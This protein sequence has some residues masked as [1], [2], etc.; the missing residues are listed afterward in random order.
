MVSLYKGV[1]RF[2]P[3]PDCKTLTFFKSILRLIKFFKFGTQSYKS[4]RNWFMSNL[5]D[6]EL[7]LFL[8]AFTNLRY[9]YK[10]CLNVLKT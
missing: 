4:T 1:V 6:E 7:D 2:L 10:R 3:V 9:L 8:W 5:F